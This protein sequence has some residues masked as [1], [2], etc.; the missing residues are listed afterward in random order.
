[1]NSVRLVWK[2]LA[3]LKLTIAIL[4]SLMVLVVM[5]TVAQVNMGTYGAVRTYMRSF[6]VWWNIS[7]SGHYLP[8]FPGGV[9][10]GSL[11][12]VN[13][14]VAQVSRLRLSWRKVGLWLAHAGLILLVGGE[15]VSAIF[16]VDA[17]M[18]VEE[19][20]TVD[21]VES[22]RDTELTLTDTTEAST[23]DEYAVPES[24]LEEGRTVEIP[25]TPISLRIER[26]V[27]NSQLRNREANDAPSPANRGVGAGV[28]V[29]ELPP[30]T[31][32][33]DLNQAA[34]VVEPWA[35]GRSYGTWLVSRVLG[36][37]QSFVHEGRTYSLGMRARREYLPYSITLKDFRHD[38]YPGTDIP[39]NF[40]SLVHLENPRRK[41]ARDVLI[42]MN[43]PLRY[44]GKTFYQSSFG[45][46]DT[47][48]IFQ[49]V[50]NPGWLIPYL[51]C[52]LVTLGLLI[53]FALVLRR[54]QRRVREA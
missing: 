22:P 1:L 13:L 28:T 40:S 20:Q 42:Y 48:S 14:V 3:S 43:Q 30:V 6:W 23:D 2:A 19:G 46:N 9:T 51:S 29:L 33:D 35:A 25:G 21:F 7:G 11:L 37:P 54:S 24:L 16:Q 10:V 38:V 53:H 47:L 4:V 50:E 18:A 26:F 52:V 12:V 5:C 41:E 34:V 27:R 31:R 32:D 17:Q 36:A 45:K 8:V 15:F 44:E 39:K 49:V